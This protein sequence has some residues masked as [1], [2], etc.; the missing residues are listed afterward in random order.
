MEAVRM[1]MSTSKT[2][3]RRRFDPNALTVRDVLTIVP[4]VLAFVAVS[5]FFAFSV[6][7]EVYI[8]WGGL[9]L[10]SAIVFGLFIKYSRQFLRERRFWGL[11]LALLAVHLVAFILILTHVEE[12]KLVWF[13]PMAAEL[14]LFLFIRNRILPID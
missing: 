7:D 3:H 11:T 8:R 9:A 1:V 14:P 13:T 2:N 10:D 12:W 5:I 4:L 6:S